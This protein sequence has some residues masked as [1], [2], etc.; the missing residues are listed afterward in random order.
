MISLFC[1]RI[2]IGKHL[3]VF[4]CLS[5]EGFLRLENKYYERVTLALVFMHLS[6]S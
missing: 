4:A 1:Q 6:W 2:L 5:I 3:F